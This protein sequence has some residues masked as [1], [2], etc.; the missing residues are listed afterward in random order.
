MCTASTDAVHIR[1]LRVQ[2]PYCFDVELAF[3]TQKNGFIHR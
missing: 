2:S 1:V 3:D